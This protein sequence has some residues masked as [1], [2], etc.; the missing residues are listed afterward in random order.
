MAT[1][2]NIRFTQK[3]SSDFL[4][5]QISLAWP[6]PGREQYQILA[7]HYTRPPKHHLYAHIWTDRKSNKYTTKSIRERR[8]F[9]FIY[10][11][12]D[13]LLGFQ[14]T[15]QRISIRVERCAGLFL[16]TGKFRV[17]GRNNIRSQHKQ[18][19]NK[20]THNW[21][22]ISVVPHHCKH[23][24]QPYGSWESPGACERCRLLHNGRTW[25]GSTSGYG[26]HHRKARRLSGVVNWPSQMFSPLW[27][28]TP[29]FCQKFHQLHGSY[30]FDTLFLC[31]TLC[32]FL[33]HSSQQHT[34][35]LPFFPFPF[36]TLLVVHLGHD[37]R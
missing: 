6:S 20:Q 1:N 37:E 22:K 16:R 28:P 24:R 17:T 15:K 27:S 35:P 23:S 8:N 2:T 33:P 10:R 36:A 19:Q 14:R 29:I 25:L 11:K 30:G 18:R 21:W 3:L 4:R 26:R 9:Q 31:S 7:L 34:A 12:R 32:K 5:F 13:L